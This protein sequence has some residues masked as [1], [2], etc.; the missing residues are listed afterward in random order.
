VTGRVLSSAVNVSEGK[1]SRVLDRLAQACGD[2][3]LDVHADPD[4]HRSVFTLAGPDVAVLSGVRS[5]VEEAVASLELGRHVGAHPRFG[6]V[7]VVPYAPVGTDDLV[8][9]LTARDATAIWAG[10][11]L[12]IPC[13]LYGPMPDGGERSLPEVRRGAFVTLVPDTGPD[14]PHPSAGALAVGAR[15]PLVAYNL[16]LVGVTDAEARAVAL[17]V[18]SRQVRT[19]AFGLGGAHQVSCNLVRPEVV[20]PADAYDLV[21]A[22]LPSGARIVRGEL[23][24]LLPESVLAA[25]PAERYGELGLSPDDVLEARLADRSLRKRRRS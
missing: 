13:F 21:R 19:L 24:G 7:D 9:A 12:G 6:V 22:A 18:R 17:R 14:R 3:L 20:G 2:V 8:G 4:H 5:L 23:V 25:V 10:A 16:W 11:V 15:G 1:D